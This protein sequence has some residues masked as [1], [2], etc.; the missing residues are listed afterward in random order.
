[1]MKTVLR[2]R[3]ILYFVVVILF[4]GCEV[5]VHEDITYAPFPDKPKPVTPI[6]RRPI[7]PGNKIP[8]PRVAIDEVVMDD[9]GVAMEMLSE[10]VE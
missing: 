1:M 7:V 6:K 3:Y 5:G 4:V 9:N 8:R 10:D 2:I